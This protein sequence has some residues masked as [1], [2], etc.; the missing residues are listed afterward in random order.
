M[1]GISSERLHAAIGYEVVTSCSRRRGMAVEYQDYL[2]AIV[3]HDPRLKPRDGRDR[4]V[5]FLQLDSNQCPP[6]SLPRSAYGRNYRR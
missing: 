4:L 3:D 2:N 6:T 1:G 5:Q